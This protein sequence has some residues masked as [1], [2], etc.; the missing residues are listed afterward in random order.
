LRYAIYGPGQS[1]SRTV[2]V[3]QKPSFR[4]R[5]TVASGA[6]DQGLQLQ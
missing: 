4:W 3:V 5:W 6:R 2:F 1:A